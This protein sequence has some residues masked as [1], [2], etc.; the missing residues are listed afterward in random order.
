MLYFLEFALLSGPL[1]GATYGFTQ[2]ALIVLGMYYSRK[3]ILIV[4]RDN[5]A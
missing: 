4:V 1:A 3:V 5:F 2:N